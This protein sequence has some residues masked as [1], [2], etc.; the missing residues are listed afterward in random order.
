MLAT[1]S[2]FYDFKS[3]QLN[4]ILFLGNKVQIKKKLFLRKPKAERFKTINLKTIKILSPYI[5]MNFS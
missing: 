4:D 5:M 2:T 3:S 1:S